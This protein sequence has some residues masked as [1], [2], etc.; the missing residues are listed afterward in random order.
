MELVEILMKIILIIWILFDGHRLKGMI[1][2]N[3]CM[4]SVY[5][6][7]ISVCTHDEVSSVL[8]LGLMTNVR[9]YGGMNEQLPGQ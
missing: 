6:N 8:F 9:Y 5:K 1:S 3:K 4:I 7:R 2:H